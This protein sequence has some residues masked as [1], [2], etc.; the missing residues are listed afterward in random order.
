MTQPVDPGALPSVEANFDFQV[1]GG[2]AGAGV[3]PAPL[4][5]TVGGQ[6]ITWNWQK[7][8]DQLSIVKPLLLAYAWL[9]A[10]FIMLG[11]KHE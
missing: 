5:F 11:A 6:V 10:A 4:H 3:C 1:E 8:C 9:S 7:F 2:F